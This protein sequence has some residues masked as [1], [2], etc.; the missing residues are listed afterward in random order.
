MPTRKNVTGGTVRELFQHDKIVEMR[1]LAKLAVWVHNYTFD[2][3]NKTTATLVVAAL[4]GDI[5]DGITT[6]NMPR[7]VKT[8]SI[9]S[10]ACDVAV[11]MMEDTL[12][13]GN[14]PGPAVLINAMTNIS[15]VGQGRPP[16]KRYIGKMNELALWFAVAPVAN[17]ECVCGT[18]LMYTYKP[19]WIPERY[20]STHYG[21]NS[22]WTNN[23]IKKFIRVSTGA[24]ILGEVDEWV[25]PDPEKP[26]K[27]A[28][29]QFPSYFPVIKMDPSKSIFLIILPLVIVGC[30]SL[31]MLWNVK[32][33][34]CMAIPIMRNATLG[35]IIKSS[36]TE[37]VLGPAA[38]DHQD[39][40]K[41][42]SLE[43]LEVRFKMGDTTLWGLHNAKGQS[44]LTE[45]AS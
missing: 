16:D 2:S 34:K 32:M 17:G 41:P 13:V 12:T 26:K 25:Y 43:K 15:V 7:K 35:E 42:S 3:A 45:R 5:R 1:D 18:Q 33:H 11:E 9:T 21:S 20:T 29:A 39:A 30:G 38:I 22:G 27:A 31:L 8:A 6:T 28:T 4:G 36:H 19:R 40:T 14:A 23:Y 44:L 24:S 37:D 10:I